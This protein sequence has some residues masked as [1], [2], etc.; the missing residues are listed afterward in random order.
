M[1]KLISGCL[2]A[3]LQGLCLSANAQDPAEKKVQDIREQRVPEQQAYAKKQPSGSKGYDLPARDRIWILQSDAK[4]AEI[5][6]MQARVNELQQHANNSLMRNLIDDLKEHRLIDD[7]KGL[8]LALTG[9][10]MIVNGKKITGSVYR[11]FRHKYVRKAGYGIFYGHPSAGDP[12]H[13]FFM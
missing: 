13:S 10:K 5:D 9:E 4:Q 11:R 2:A 1:H 12:A 8:W 6:R 7:E 3:L